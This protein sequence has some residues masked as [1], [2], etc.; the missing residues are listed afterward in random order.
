MVGLDHH[1][2]FYDIVCLLYWSI[3]LFDCPSIA[4][5]LLNTF[6]LSYYETQS[7]T[8]QLKIPRNVYT[9]LMIRVWGNNFELLE[10]NQIPDVILLDIMM[11]EMSGWETR[12]KLKE[13]KNRRD[14][15]IVF[16][17]PQYYFIFIKYRFF[18]IF[19]SLISL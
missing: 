5:A 4:Y 2:Y 19:N 8:L 3:L 12:N 18:H 9:R 10:D 7:V 15:P 1:S 14:I 6:D 13:N 16:H 11:P 17:L